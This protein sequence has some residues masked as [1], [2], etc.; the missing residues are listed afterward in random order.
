[1]RS[2]RVTPNTI[3]TPNE[4][5]A[6]HEDAR[7]ASRLL[8]H[9]MY[10]TIALPTNPTAGQ[11]ITFVINGTSIVLTCVATLS[12]A[13]AGSFLKGA[14]AAATD[15]NLFQLL[16]N[17]TITN[18]T[19]VAIGVNTSANVTFINYIAWSLA[20]TSII[21]SSYAF[22]L[23][24]PDTSFSATTNITGGS[25][26]ANTMALYIEPG[27]VYVNGTEVYFTGGVTPTVTAPV[28]NPRIDVLTI[29]SSGT[30]AWTTGTEN[31]SP[32]TPSYP[33]NQIPICE[34]YNVVGETA[35]YDQ[36]N[37]HSGEGYISNDVRPFLSTGI[38]LA[39][40]ANSI[41][42]DADGTR[43][44]G[45]P[46]FEWNN[47]YIK[48]GI[49]LNGSSINAQMLL[50]TTAAEGVVAGAALA[51]GY[52]QSDGGIKVDGSISAFAVTGSSGVYSQSITVGSN[53]NRVLFVAIRYRNNGATTPSSV[54]F[55]SVAITNIDGNVNSTNGGLWT[56]YLV[57][58]TA[59][60]F[61]ITWTISGVGS[62]VA[63]LYVASLYNCVQ[64][65]QPD[66]HA[67]VSNI[68]GAVVT[69]ATVT[70]SIGAFLM[71][72]TGSS[73][74]LG[75]GL[76]WE[77]NGSQ[78]GT[79]IT[80]WYGDANK[81]FPSVPITAAASGVGAGIV[82]MV[83]IAPFTTPTLGA[84]V[85]ASAA[86]SSGTYAD[87]FSGY[88]SLAFIGFAVASASAGASLNAVLAGVVSGLSGLTPSFQ[89]LLAN[90]GGTI[91][92]VAGSITRK[93]GIAIST[94]QLI[95]TNIW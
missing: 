24:T 36:S 47:L 46:S 30:L 69:T 82:T 41:I 66:T 63:V 21:A 87:N 92:T 11:I 50:A 7:G 1:M 94:T 74:I 93:V 31:A 37:Q 90:T 44:L 5:N 85:N 4:W 75:G 25:Y 73:S 16:Q 22:S 10:G 79:G 71:T 18:T 81:T 13:A 15:A 86:N 6:L 32:V 40:V 60:T 38:N 3:G 52:Y 61:N 42:P 43:N 55:N 14:T 34:I 80:L 20:G 33:A 78:S 70:P 23:Y 39:A 29:N 91:A 9:Q 51:T 57:A 17:P 72:L 67:F 83:S 95:V 45:S 88:R 59:G 26:T 58:P 77:N 28:S 48:S 62:D 12:G 65:S 35:L 68:S 54:Q 89:Y 56:G 84:V 49:F 76:A 2:S 19:Q 27:V 8:P 64:T 53:S